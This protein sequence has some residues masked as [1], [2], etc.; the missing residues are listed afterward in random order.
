MYL[1]PDRIDYVVELMNKYAVNGVVDGSNPEYKAEMAKVEELFPTPEITY[2]QGPKTDTNITGMVIQYNFTQDQLDTYEKNTGGP[3]KVTNFDKFINEE[4]RNDDSVP[5]YIPIANL[6]NSVVNVI[7]STS[8]PST[9]LP[10]TPTPATPTPSTPTPAAATTPQPFNDPGPGVIGNGSLTDAQINSLTPEQ[11]AARIPLGGAIKGSGGDYSDLD[12]FKSY[13]GWQNVGGGFE[14]W[15]KIAE[16]AGYGKKDKISS[17]MNIKSG[18]DAGTYRY[19]DPNAPV[20]EIA[21]PTK[22]FYLTSQHGN[23]LAN[24]GIDGVSGNIFTNKSSFVYMVDRNTGQ[25]YT[26]D[27]NEGKS[28]EMGWQ[29]SAPG[30]DADLMITS[31]NRK[32]GDD[33]KNTGDISAYNLT[34]GGTVDPETSASWAAQAA[35]EPGYEKKENQQKFQET[36]AQMEAASGQYQNNIE[37]VNATTPD[38]SFDDMS[39]SEA[40]AAAR[41]TL[42]AGQTFSWK[43]GSYT[44]NLA[45]DPS[46]DTTTTYNAFGDVVTEGVNDDNTLQQQST[47]AQNIIAAQDDET[48]DAMGET[49]IIDDVTIT[50]TTLPPQSADTVYETDPFTGGVS[51]IPIGP[52]SFVD[53]VGLATIVPEDTVL[54]TDTTPVTNLSGSSTTYQSTAPM[55]FNSNIWNPLVDGAD[56]SKLKN[57]AT[58][59]TDENDPFTPLVYNSDGSRNSDVVAQ[60]LQ[61]YADLARALRYNDIPAGLEDLT[62]AEINGIKNNIQGKLEF[63][64]GAAK[65]LG[66][67]NAPNI[68]TQPGNANLVDYGQ[69]GIVEQLYDQGFQEKQDQVSA[70]DLIEYNMFGDPLGVTDSGDI[71][72]TDQMLAGLSTGDLQPPN[73]TQAGFFDF[74]GPNMADAATLPGEE[75]LKEKSPGEIMVENLLN[76]FKGATNPGDK[77][78]FGEAIFQ[79]L[80]G[81]DDPDTIGEKI[82]LLIN[83]MGAAAAGGFLSDTIAGGTEGTAKYLDQFLN[84]LRG[85]EGI[86]AEGVSSELGDQTTTF[87]DFVKPFTQ[88]IDSVGADMYNQMSEDMQQRVSENASLAEGTTW[89]EVF[90]GTAKTK[91]GAN[92]FDD[93]A[94]LLVKGSEDLYDVLADVVTGLGLGKKGIALVMGM[95]AGEGFNSADQEAQA[96]ITEYIANNPDEFAKIVDQQFNGDKQ[97]AEN[98]MRNGASFIASITAGPAEGIGDALMVG[99]IKKVNPFAS[100]SLAANPLVNI[101]AK[102]IVAVGTGGATEAIAEGGKNVALDVGA[103]IDTPLMEGTAKAFFEGT[104]GSAPGSTVGAASEAIDQAGTDTG[105]LGPEDFAPKPDPTTGLPTLIT[106]V[107]EG[108]PGTFDVAESTIT[109]D[110]IDPTIQTGISTLVQPVPEGDT[111]EG[112]FDDLTDQQTISNFVPPNV[113]GTAT[114]PETLTTEYEK[115]AGLIEDK[116]ALSSPE[117][118][119]ATD[120]IKDEIAN[121]GALSSTTAI[122]ISNTTGMSLQDV[123]NIAEAEMGLPASLATGQ[124]ETITGVT[125]VKP[126]VILDPGSLNPP[127]GLEQ[128]DSPLGGGTATVDT[129]DPLLTPDMSTAVL[130]QNQQPLNVNVISEEDFKKLQD[131]ATTSTLDD[132]INQAIKQQEQLVSDL[133]VDTVDP[134]LTPDME[135]AVFEGT[136]EGVEQQVNMFGDIVD[137]FQGVDDNVLAQQEQL[138][139]T[140]IVPTQTVTQ[141]LTGIGTEG[142]T[143]IGSTADVKTAVANTVQTEDAKE[144]IEETPASGVTTDLLDAVVQEDQPLVEEKETS[145]IEEVTKTN[146]PTPETQKV[147]VEEKVSEGETLAAE[148]TTE[149][150]DTTTTDVFDNVVDVEFEDITDQQAIDVDT[151]TEADTVVTTDQITDETVTPELITTDVSP[152]AL[153]TTDTVVTTDVAPDPDV[154]TEQQTVITTDLPADDEVDISTI[155][156]PE[157]EV[158]VE[159]ADSDSDVVNPVDAPFEC[160]DGYDT[161]R[162]ADGTY[163]C[164]KKGTKMVGRRR[165]AT[166]PYLSKRGFA[167]P[168]PYGPSIKTVGTTVDTVPATKKAS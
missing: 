166:N 131:E 36:L 88:Y 89:G 148:P 95:S 121:T 81:D 144:I 10:A 54:A 118:L 107:P 21:D 77:Y 47:T 87:Q 138:A 7:P 168:S 115:A 102:G 75:I 97:K 19:V 151:D 67:A 157:E 105:P 101:P 27:A 160:P 14:Q 129:V 58:F 114:G 130:N 32:V 92:M 83:D 45:P 155:G 98:E 1:N 26:Y 90:T 85:G 128:D 137:D 133:G 13:S 154:T 2:V 11:A 93:P 104:I 119:A 35:H 41:D 122:N 43:G 126:D 44:T 31:I 153:T 136:D 109:G 57:Y 106:T 42:G 143:G 141:A 82:G 156:D 34:F 146:V 140:N 59:Q 132:S 69:T 78:T 91:S 139:Q 23:S 71:T 55:L 9:P 149:V 12:T 39:F 74:L 68:D 152:D 117:V 86:Q 127:Q 4:T 161:V 25:G 116:S 18:A 162:Q 8:T 37:S 72:P 79:N 61:H 103:G 66:I 96:R 49:P 46:T 3:P 142:T 134:L 167:G 145:N 5:D 28:E 53:D 120:I 124:G 113:G 29:G 110:V 30:P 20:P 60:G 15:K 99:A 76:K 100:T 163:I 51:T 63:F 65:S 16:K 135:K 147:D 80:F 40:F 165:I 112:Q 6:P 48:F 62:Q 24:V 123:A 52:E 159:V 73:V 33:W 17:D 111:L 70:A 64:N 38:K 164:V 94:A 50:Q 150:K 22:P 125:P 158:E 84:Y 56:Y 108:G